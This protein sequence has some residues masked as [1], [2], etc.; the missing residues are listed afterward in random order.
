MPFGGAHFQSGE[1]FLSLG[2]FRKATLASSSGLREWV[3]WDIEKKYPLHQP[4]AFVLSSHT[5]TYTCTT[6]IWN[7]SYPAKAIPP[8]ILGTREF[9][10][11]QEAWII[12]F[13]RLTC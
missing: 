13:G 11:C 10:R 3:R 1:V 12:R 5:L 6:D 8:I 9:C 2:N 4:S 7:N